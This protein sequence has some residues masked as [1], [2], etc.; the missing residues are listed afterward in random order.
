MQLQTN[1]MANQ[2]QVGT[3]IATATADMATKTQVGTDITAA[4][5]ELTKAFG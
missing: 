4:K 5:T 3:D 1:D 2:T